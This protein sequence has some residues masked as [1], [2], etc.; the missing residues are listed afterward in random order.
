M[1]EPDLSTGERAELEHLRAEV[2]E[3]AGG[4]L[5]VAGHL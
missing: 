5:G 3:L 2:T 1:G 4:Q